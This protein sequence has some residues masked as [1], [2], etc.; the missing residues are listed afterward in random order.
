MGLG[1]LIK[2]PE[3]GTVLKVEMRCFRTTCKK[4]EL[5]DT[6][7]PKGGFEPLTVIGSIEGR[8]LN[9]GSGT[10]EGTYQKEVQGRE[11]RFTRGGN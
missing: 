6:E 7:L 9:R 5:Q 10:K 3:R 4:A 11:I 1:E 2:R 8:T